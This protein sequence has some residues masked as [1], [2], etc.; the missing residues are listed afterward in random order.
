MYEQVRLFQTDRRY[1]INVVTVRP[2]FLVRVCGR[3]R[4][5]WKLVSQEAHHSTKKRYDGATT[6][7][8]AHR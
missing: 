1:Y 4:F 2:F 5:L 8:G 7:G 6:Q 3:V